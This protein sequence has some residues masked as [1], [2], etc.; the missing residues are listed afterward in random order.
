M[1]KYSELNPAAKQVAV[2]GFME[3]AKQYFGNGV[4]KSLVYE[5]LSN[6]KVHHFDQTGIIVGKMYKKNGVYHLKSNGLY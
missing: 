3:K 1:L 4:E 5:F 2:D 6:S